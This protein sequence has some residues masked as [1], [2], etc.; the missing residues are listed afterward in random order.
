MPWDPVLK[1]N[2]R[3][4]AFVG[5]YEQYK[6]LRGKAPNAQRISAIQTHT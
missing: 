6:R 5:P 1:Q 3:F 2:L 4:S